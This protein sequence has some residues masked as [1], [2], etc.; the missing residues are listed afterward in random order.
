MKALRHFAAKSRPFRT[1]EAQSETDFKRQFYNDFG[2][3]KNPIGSLPCFDPLKSS[4]RR[5]TVKTEQRRTIPLLGPDEVPLFVGPHLQRRGCQ[6][7]DAR[8]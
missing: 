8:A 7:R 1:K 3:L 6:R 2:E 5:A 4:S